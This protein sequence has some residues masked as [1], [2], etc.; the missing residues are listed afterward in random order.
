M[1][2]RFRNWSDLRVFLAVYR[3]GSTLAAARHLGVAQPTV[4]RRIEVLEH[5]LGLT[6]FERDT[7]GFHPTQ[8]ASTLLP[9]IEAIEHAVQALTEQAHDLAAPGVIRI[10]AFAA[11]FSETITDIIA[12]FTGQYPDVGFEFLPST[13]KYDLMAGEAD[14]ALRLTLGGDPPDLI[15]RRIGKARFTLYGTPAYAERHGLPRTPEDMAG[16]RLYSVVQKGMAPILHGWLLHHVPEEALARVF[17]EI[18]MLEAAVRNGHGLA[19]NNLGR[20]EED[21]RAGRLIRCFDPPEDWAIDHVMLISPDAWRRQEV[22]AF[23]KFFAPR[24]AALFAHLR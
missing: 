22:K 17:S 14:V 2:S 24:Y 4:A 7:R 15:S 21:E 11:N 19:I 6:L 3:E 13:R 1:L 20:N 10:T 23:V 16:H 18:G 8:A 9:Q 5:E 12:D